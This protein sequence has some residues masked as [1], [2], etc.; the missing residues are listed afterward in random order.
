M[1]NI[2]LNWNGVDSLPSNFPSVGTVMPFG[3]VQANPT[4]VNIFAALQEAN[5]TLS[6]TQDQISELQTYV[7]ENCLNSR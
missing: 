1:E 5:T 4:I 6:S 7:I 3:K 2:C